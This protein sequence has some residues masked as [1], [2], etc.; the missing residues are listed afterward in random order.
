MKK[1]GLFRKP[2]AWLEEKAPGLH[3]FLTTDEKPKPAL[4]EAAGVAIVL[5]LLASILWG[6][7]GQPLNESPV[8]VIE[9]ESM[10][11]CDQGLHLEL[12][13]KVCKGSYG[14]LGT[15]D[16]GD[17]VFV[18]DVEKRSDVT[19]FA[20]CEASGGK[21]RYGACG[22]TIIYRP[23]G[24]K[25]VTPII[26]RAMFYLEI[27]GDGTYSIPGLGLERIR[28]L[29]DHRI[30]A[31]GLPTNYHEVLEH[32]NAGPE[33]SGFI[34][35]GDNNRG[36]D[37]PNLAPLPVRADWIIGKARGEVPW[38]GLLKLWLSDLVGPTDN[39]AENAPG[40]TKT[41]M[42]LTVTLLVGGPVAYEA[43]KRRRHRVH[44]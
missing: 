31:L 43:I 13:A 18:R 5:L 32:A 39:Y 9:S 40:D 26:H 42:W 44:E 4:R 24:S 17:L 38:I 27:H 35:W 28:D 20:A 36:A 3:D 19:T 11:R 6:A 16:A 15:I 14:R 21:E 22:D 33:D 10:I 7:T 12:D 30:Q 2:L 1:D 25:A 23:G 41:M 34:T 8:V 29:S 37:Q